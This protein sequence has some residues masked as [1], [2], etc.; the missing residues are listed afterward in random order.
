MTRFQSESAKS[1]EWPGLRHA[2]IPIDSQRFARVI[3]WPCATSSSFTLFN[4]ISQSVSFGGARHQ[5]CSRW[6][7]LPSLIFG[8]NGFRAIIAKPRC[9]L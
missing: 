5:D 7:Q 4:K 1:K 9:I 6:P 8:V 2:L 3:I